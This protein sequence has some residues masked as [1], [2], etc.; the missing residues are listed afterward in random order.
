MERLT[1]ENQK[2]SNNQSNYTVLNE[3]N[4]NLSLY[5]IHKLLN[6]I[7]FKFSLQIRYNWQLIFMLLE[8]IKLRMYLLNTYLKILTTKIIRLVF[9]KL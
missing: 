9:M 3:V 1:S 4:K 2:Y 7:L 6:K 5:Q 8:K